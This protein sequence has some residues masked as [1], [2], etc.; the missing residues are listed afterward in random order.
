MYKKLLRGIF[1][2]TIIIIS[3]YTCVYAFNVSLQKEFIVFDIDSIVICNQNNWDEMPW[4]E[5]LMRG[6]E[7]RIKATIK[8]HGNPTEIDS[9]EITVKTS[10][11]NTQGI[12]ITL[13]ETGINTNEFRGSIS[14]DL[15]VPSG[16][17]SVIGEF[18]SGDS[19]TD[20][21]SVA[22]ENKY[23]G[24]NSS[25]YR[26]G[27]R[28]PGDETNK[29]PES[30]I[31]FFKSGG[32]EQ[33]TV[34]SS[35][36]KN[37]ICVVQNQSDIFYI[38]S[39]GFS[40]NFGILEGSFEAKNP[41]STNPPFDQYEYVYSDTIGASWNEDVNTIIFAC[42]S[43]LDI[44][45]S[46]GEI[47]NPSNSP[48]IGWWNKRG[49]ATMLCGYSFSSP[50]GEAATII[51]EWDGTAEGWM[52]VNDKHQNYNS[53]VIIND[54]YWYWGFVNNK[55]AIIKLPKSQW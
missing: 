54:E 36:G 37:D 42:C 51:Q 53:V 47:T 39:H 28:N 7:L 11:T 1:V 25:K 16:N 29:I 19:T 24:S 10:I 23:G 18:A 27:A 46:S 3:S 31:S 55:R 26:G 22:F 21:D 12:K 6:Q 34:G 52:G 4:H 35:N 44:H 41:N 45:N 14:T 8:P 2:V 33:L 50:M 43:V 48:G 38:S 40:A 20:E 15:L 17:D 49:T 13:T 32:I 9:F 5:V 30:T